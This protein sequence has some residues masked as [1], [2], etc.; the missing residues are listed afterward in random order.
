VTFL[1]DAD[2]TEGGCC[3]PETVIGSLRSDA[4][5]LGRAIEKN[6]EGLAKKAGLATSRG[7]YRLSR[8][9][10]RYPTSE[11]LELAE[12]RVFVGIPRVAGFLEQIGDGEVDFSAGRSSPLILRAPGEF[13]S[14][15]F[16]LGLPLILAFSDDAEARFAHQ[17]SALGFRQFKSA[18]GQLRRS[19]TELLSIE[20]QLWEIA[21]ETIPYATRFHLLEWT[22]HP[23]AA[24]HGD[25]AYTFCLRCGDLLLRDRLP[26]NWNAARRPIGEAPRCARCQK[27]G[28]NE[29]WP[30]H[31]ICP[32]GRSRDKRGLEWWLR[33]QD[34]TCSEPFLGERGSQYCSAHKDRNRSP[35]QRR[36]RQ[37]VGLA[38]TESS[39]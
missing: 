5:L 19:L 30:D 11:A 37:A 18:R 9:E 3:P 12:R 17:R 35:A 13:S 1:H 36:N 16:F 39:R 6:P 25:F 8:E 33:C 23:E 22:W 21:G 20:Q 4:E 26:P 32:A 14:E 29:Q 27:H 28:R 15:G 34:E 24:Q 38:D 2:S 7:P 10:G 31:A